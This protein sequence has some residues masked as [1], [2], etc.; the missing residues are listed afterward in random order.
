MAGH[1]IISFFFC[2]EAIVLVILLF[3]FAVLAVSVFE[4]SPW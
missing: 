1:S 3:Y 4:N 2:C